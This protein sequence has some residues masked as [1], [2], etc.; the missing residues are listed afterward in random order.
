MRV[1]SVRMVLQLLGVWGWGFQDF[2][3]V[4]MEPPEYY[5]SANADN[6]IR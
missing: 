4:S 5:G 6:V 3:S 2:Q 1:R